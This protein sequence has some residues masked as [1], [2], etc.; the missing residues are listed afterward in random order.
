MENVHP[1][2]WL[3]LALLVGGLGFAIYELRRATAGKAAAENE[4]AGARV[5][6]E[7]LA[8]AQSDLATLRGEV[9]QTL[10]RAVEA[11]ALL[12]GLQSVA[13]QD[14]ARFLAVAQKA[15]AASRQDFLA[16]AGQTFEKHKSEAAGSVQA[17]LGPVQEQFKALTDRVG[18]L[19]TQNTT[20]DTHI[21]QI[22]QTMRETQTAARNLE[23]ALKAAP[24]ARGNWGEATLRN[25]LEL[26]GL[27]PHA[28]FMEQTTV[29]NDDAKMLR[30][31]V[32][33]RMPGGG[34]LVIDSK[35]ALAG[36]F[37]AMEAVDDA[38]R[39]AGLKRHADQ[40]KA[41]AK[42]LAQADYSAHV[43]S[44][45]D[46]VVMFLPGENF[47]IAA[48]EH[49]PE[50]FEN[51]ARNKVIICTPA[52][53]VA[54]AKSVAYGWRQEES[55]KNAAEIA[56]LGR[57]LY[58]RVNTVAEKIAAVGNSL[59]K[60][61]RNYNDLVSSVESRMLPQARRFKELGVGDPGIEIEVLDQIETAPKQIT[62]PDAFELSPPPITGKKR[63]S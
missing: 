14:E 15:L 40:I 2:F 59:E 33:V 55:A 39:A 62:A 28:D 8:A 51:A 5:K 42:R 30:P 25:V 44:A 4:L 20:I 53:M 58:K 47:Y 7:A 45:V 9:A 12:K 61:V 17:L 63:A 29:T 18:A 32:V 57:E 16:V 1:I 31:D 22:A 49:D 3:A 54:L 46:F 41:H 38:G 60:S 37:E 56:D 11:E 10:A 26:A 13:D 35:V 21:T 52:T 27:S 43:P 48:L 36:Y 24:K 6:L 19:A 34:A 23:N 50:I